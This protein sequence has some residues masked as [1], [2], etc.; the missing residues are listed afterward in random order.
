MYT[1]GK[2]N[3]QKNHEKS[4][5]Y[6]DDVYRQVIIIRA[7]MRIAIKRFSVGLP[8]PD[9]ILLMSDHVQRM[10]SNLI[11]LYAQRV[12][13]L[14]MELASVAIT[15]YKFPIRYIREN[16]FFFRITESQRVILPIIVFS[17]I[18]WMFRHYRNAQMKHAERARK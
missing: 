6:I 1:Y 10:Y 14:S 5:P 11:K 12:I 16:A 13:I 15:Y 2:K 18:L 7:H 4:F 9:R 3:L 17:A 8:F